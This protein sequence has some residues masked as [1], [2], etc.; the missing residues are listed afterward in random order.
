[1]THTGSGRHRADWPRVRVG[2]HDGTVAPIPRFSEGALE[3]IC[4]CLGEAVTGSQITPLLADAGVS[5]STGGSGTKWRRLHENLAE[6]QRRD[7]AGNAVA[8]V[9]QAVLDPVCFTGRP[10][11]FELRRTELNQVLALSGLTLHD[12]GK[13]RQVTAART[14]T[15]AQR[16]A[17]NLQRT[18]RERG[19]HPDVLTACSAEILAENY[20]HTVLEATKSLAEKIRGRTGLGSDGARLADEAFGLGGKAM[21][22][23]RFRS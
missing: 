14:L 11:E 16:R 10:E 20:F 21:P 9:V 17:R 2:R 22:A 4:R 18:L 8:S 6:R 13:L 5:D 15:E 7:G 1:M 12:D 23:P 19:V 3:Q